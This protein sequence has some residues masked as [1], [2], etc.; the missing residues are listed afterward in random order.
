VRT[1]A[2]VGAV[3][4]Q[5]LRR[6][7]VE[8]QRHAAQVEHGDRVAQ[9][10]H[11]GLAGDGDDVEQAVREEAL[12]QR[13]G[14][15]REGQRRQV[16]GQVDAAEHHGDVGD[17]GH[18]H[19]DEHQRHLRAVPPRG[20][21]VATQQVEGSQRQPRVARQ[22]VDP[23]PVAAHDE[24]SAVDAL[25]RAPQQ[26]VHRVGPRKADRDRR[27][28]QEQ[29]DDE[30]VE[31]RALARVVVGEDDEGDGQGGDPQV[32][33]LHPEELEPGVGRGELHALGE[34]PHGAG[35]GEEGEAARAPD[36]G[37]ARPGDRRQQQE[38]GDDGP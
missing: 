35:E 5:Q 28:H 2:I 23:E 16:D 20:A 21:D 17:P 33:E 14:A 29:R 36:G 26:V 1:D 3:E 12:R 19:R 25:H 24:Q 7:R 32:L 15:H 34:R 22:G 27:Q 6:R 30:A 31:P 13:G 37:T 18:R 8:L 38:H 4:P 9:V 11:D 10:A